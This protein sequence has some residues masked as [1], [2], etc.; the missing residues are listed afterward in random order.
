MNPRKL[1]LGLPLAAASLLLATPASAEVTFDWVTVG[2]PG[3][4]ADTF[5]DGA[6]AYVYRI[7]ET[8]VSN[9]QYAELR[10]DTDGLPVR[11]ETGLAY[12]SQ[13]VAGRDDGTSTGV[14]HACGH[15]IHISSLIASGRYLASIQSQWSGSLVLLFQPAEEGRLVAA[16]LLQG[17]PGLFGKLLLLS[18][19]LAPA[20]AQP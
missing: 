8:E 17:A 6:V 20:L 18:P 16:L 1:S 10:A 13:I 11:E 3:N 14:M 5:G 7:S 9:A 19:Q 4:A 15:D 2:N 12:A